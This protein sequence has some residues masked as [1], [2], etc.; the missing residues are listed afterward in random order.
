MLKG[1]VAFK[2]ELVERDL[3]QL[4]R[5]HLCHFYHLHKLIIE[6]DSRNAVKWISEPKEAPWRMRK[7]IG[8]IE[9]LKMHATNWSIVHTLREGNEMADGLTKA[10]AHG[11]ND[12][13][14]VYEN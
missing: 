1:K 5:K 6:S 14:E 2:E 10:E 9:N 4:S 13:V 11:S 8:H 12:L 7:L 3:L